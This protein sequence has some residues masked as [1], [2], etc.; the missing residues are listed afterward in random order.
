MPIGF[1][2]YE[3]GSTNESSPTGHNEHLGTRSSGS[4]SSSGSS[5]SSSGSTGSTGGTSSSGGSHHHDHNPNPNPQPS[6][7]QAQTNFNNEAG[8]VLGESIAAAGVN[9]YDAQ[10][11]SLLSNPNANYLS[12]VNKYT[13]A[14]SEDLP[15][16]DAA[17][18]VKEI[19][20]TSQLDTGVLKLN[21]PMTGSQ[22]A[23]DLAQQYGGTVLK[24]QDGYLVRFTNG[25]WNYNVNIP[26]SVEESSSWNSTKSDGAWRETNYSLASDN[27]PKGTGNAVST[28]NFLV[29]ADGETLPLPKG[30][31]GPGST[32]TGKG[33]SYTGGS[34]GNGL[35]SRVT[36]IRIMDPTP[37]YPKGYVVYM[38]N[39]GQTVDPFKG[40]T[41]V[42]PSDP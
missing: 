38:N 33:F 40:K 27:S 26:D 6:L 42:S 11:S 35:N 17:Q 19:A 3:G 41:T 20:I 29:S 14:N 9:L 13:G 4:T 32:D 10:Q 36:G 15:D 16:T 30:A 21:T 24:T 34:G 5:G 7:A 31:T 28:P 39:M 23:D 22:L 1:G 2:S 37:R 25:Y 18:V 12:N 8:V